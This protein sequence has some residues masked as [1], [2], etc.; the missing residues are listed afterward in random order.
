MLRDVPALAA[1]AA[2]LGAYVARCRAGEQQ[3][4]EDGPELLRLDPGA[5]PGGDRFGRGIRLLS[6]HA[7]LLDRAGRGVP[8]AYTS[9]I[10]V[11]RA[12][13]PGENRAPIR[14]HGLEPGKV[15]SRAVVRR[16]AYEAI[17]AGLSQPERLGH[18]E[19]PLDELR[20]R[21]DQLDPNVLF[22]Q[23]P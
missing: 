22:G 21:R 12:A 1:A 14:I 6:R 23:M 13:V 5:G 18:R 8:A 2:H 16:D 17:A 3:T 4:S 11:H 15:K 10:E 9:S 19:R 7:A 20:L